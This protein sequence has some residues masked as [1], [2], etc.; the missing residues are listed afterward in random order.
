M[1]ENNSPDPAKRPSQPSTEAIV[2]ALT[3]EDRLNAERET[4]GK[5]PLTEPLAGDL[6]VTYLANT[7][8]GRRLLVRED[9]A[10]LP[11]AADELMDRALAN[12]THDL[13]EI[14]LGEHSHLMMVQTGRDLEA[15]TLLLAG[16]WDQLAAQM[17]GD[18]AVGV[19]SHDL[20]LIGDTASAEAMDELRRAVPQLHA[21]DADNALSRQLFVWRDGQW[22]LLERP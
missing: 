11:V 16:L 4:D 19:P 20:V 8:D 13:S 18:I 15:C 2:P 6:V 9:L 21:P 17:D 1:S 3:T 7:T 12:L 22:A 14:Q 5:N 10:L